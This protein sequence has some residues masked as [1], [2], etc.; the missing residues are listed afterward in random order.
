MFYYITSWSATF[1]DVLGIPTFIQHVLPDFTLFYQF[2][3]F[4]CKLQLFLPSSVSCFDSKVSGACSL[5]KKGQKR[6]VFFNKKAKT[7]K[8]YLFKAIIFTRF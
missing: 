1:V 3:V 2:S 5:L 7:I 8:D 4:R 6:V